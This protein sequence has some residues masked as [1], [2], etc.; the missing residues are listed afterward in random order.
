[1]PAMTK[2]EMW[3]VLVDSVS[4]LMENQGQLPGPITPESAL[5]RDLG[6]SSVDT[7]HLFLA[8]EDRLEQPLEFEKLA[9]NNGEYRTDLTVGEL[10]EFVAAA[11]QSPGTSGAASA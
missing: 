9:L 4:E 1:M 6:V 7:V 11:C 3:K 8:L 5:S 2:D 10:W